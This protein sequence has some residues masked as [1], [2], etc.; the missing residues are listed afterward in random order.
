MCQQTRPG[1]QLGPVTCLTAES[2]LLA[3][4][5]VGGGGATLLGVM[6]AMRDFSIAEDISQVV[7]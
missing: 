7:Q 4:V 3:G 1:P 5:A 2:S 6:C